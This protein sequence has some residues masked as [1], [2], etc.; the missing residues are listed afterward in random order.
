MNKSSKTLDYCFNHH[1]ASKPGSSDHSHV[2]K[3]TANLLPLPSSAMSIDWMSHLGVQLQLNQSLLRR[4]LRQQC[5]ALEFL[6]QPGQEVFHLKIGK[7]LTDAYPRSVVE[8]HVF[9]L[10]TWSPCFCIVYAGQPSC[11]E[12][13]WVRIERDPTPS[14]RPPDVH[15]VNAK[16]RTML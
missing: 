5:H 4:A 1:Q 6:A 16:V 11:A 15:V 12:S 10:I 8:G 9:P 7:S 14:L 2:S 3:R 13:K